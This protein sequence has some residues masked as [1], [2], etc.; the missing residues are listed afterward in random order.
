MRDV[1]L[2]LGLYQR[3]DL[4][5]DQLI[6]RHYGLDEIRAGYADLAGGRNIRGVIEFAA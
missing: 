5:L 2:L 1:P 4:E 6:S 3:G